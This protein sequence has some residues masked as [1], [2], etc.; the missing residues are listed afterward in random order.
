[1]QVSA[2]FLSSENKKKTIEKLNN[3]DIDFIHVDY[4]D[5]KFVESKSGTFSSFEKLLQ[6][7]KKPLDVH[8]MAIPTN[9]LIE[10]FA[11]LNTSYITLHVE[12][13]DIEKYIELIKNYGIKVGLSIKPN[14]SIGK[15]YPYL[16]KIDLVLIM[17]V[18][19]GLGG[20]PFIESTY[21]KIKVL[22]EKIKKEKLSTMISVDGGINEDN[23]KELE[24]DIVV[25]G[26]FITNQ[27]NYQLQINKLR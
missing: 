8:L 14:T 6:G 25:S 7:N 3:T 18:E 17:S 22:K 21:E 24:V 1:M 26:N 4:M 27:N 12:I 2:S 13:K 15:L 16:D 19:P 9:L 11:L 20:Q 23:A 10:K 5:G